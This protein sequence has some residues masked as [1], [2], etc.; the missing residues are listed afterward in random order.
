MPWCRGFRVA[1]TTPRGPEI[2]LANSFA[3]A[4][5][6]TGYFDTIFLAFWKDRH[7]IS[8]QVSDYLFR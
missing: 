1:G 2:I 5:K 7:Y 3:P 4:L 6:K 8:S